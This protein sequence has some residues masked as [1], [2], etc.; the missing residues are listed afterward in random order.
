LRQVTKTAYMNGE[1]NLEFLASNYR[2]LVDAYQPRLAA[3]A[4][5][6]AKASELLW[7]AI[8]KPTKKDPVISKLMPSTHL[9]CVSEHFAQMVRDFCDKGDPRFFKTEGDTAATG[10]PA[11]AHFEALMHLKYLRRSVHTHPG[12]IRPAAVLAQ[13]LTYILAL[14][15]SSALKRRWARTIRTVHGP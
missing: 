2:A 6:T 9:S 10:K 4:V 3:Q 7:A 13:R 8:K 11:P 1:S 14:A 15:D 12:A 5:D